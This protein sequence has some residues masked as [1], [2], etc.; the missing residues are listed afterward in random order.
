[1]RVAI[2]STRVV[3]ELQVSM[4]A[5]TLAKTTNTEDYYSELMTVVSG[6][7]AVNIAV[8]IVAVCVVTNTLFPISLHSPGDT[9]TAPTTP[10]AMHVSRTSSSMQAA[11]IH[12]QSREYFRL[13]LP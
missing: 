1:M 8:E 10:S 6:L 12:T 7:F 2:E 4:E 11:T 3:Y 9:C 13:E 5:C